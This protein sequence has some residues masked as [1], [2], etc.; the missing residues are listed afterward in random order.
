MVDRASLVCRVRLLLPASDF[1]GQLWS[2]RTLPNKQLNSHAGGNGHAYG[3]RTW[4]LALVEFQIKLEDL[5]ICQR[6]LYH[7]LKYPCARIFLYS[8]RLWRFGAIRLCHGIISTETL[9]HGKLALQR[10][11]SDSEDAMRD[12][13]YNREQLQVSNFSLEIAHTNVK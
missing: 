13:L 6:M 10:M 3:S 1:L 5:H 11:T 12:V 9:L 7:G 2:A 8:L 4:L